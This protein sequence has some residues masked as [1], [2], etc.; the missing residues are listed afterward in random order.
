MYIE[1]PYEFIIQGE[2]MAKRVLTLIICFCLLAVSNKQVVAFE[3]PVVEVEISSLDI[4]PF[5]II[6][7]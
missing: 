4:R 3:K 5:Y 1:F 2:Y 6:N 7:Q